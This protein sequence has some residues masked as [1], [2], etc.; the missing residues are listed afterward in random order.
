MYPIVCMSVDG[1]WLVVL[2]PVCILYKCENLDVYPSVCMDGWM[3]IPQYVK[4]VGCVSPCLYGWL[5]VY[6]PVCLDGWMVGCV[7]PSM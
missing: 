2:L 6:P 1:G 4:M 5:D 7:S 3:C